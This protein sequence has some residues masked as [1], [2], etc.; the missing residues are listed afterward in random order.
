[1]MQAVAGGCR[2]SWFSKAAI[3]VWLVCAPLMYA[4]EHHGQVLS[5]NLPVP[6]ATVIAT[7]GMKKFATVTDV[8]GRYAFP[9]LPDGV[10]QL[11][12]EMPFFTTVE[13]AITV[14]PKAPAAKWNLKVLP[15]PQALAQIKM[16]KTATSSA[17]ASSTSTPKVDQATVAKKSTNDDGLL[18]NGSMDNAATSRF[19]LNQAFGNTR[20]NSHNLYNGGFG[21]VLGNSALDARPYSLTGLDTPQSNYSEVTLLADIGGPLNIPHLWHRGPNFSAL[22]LW[23]RDSTAIAESGLVPTLAQRTDTV[24][25]TDPVAQALLAYY[26]LPNL[27]GN[28]NY[29]YQIPVL[30]GTH[31]DAPQIRMN[32]DIGSSGDSIS[33]SFALESTR[34][35][36]TNLFGFRDNTATLGLNTTINYDHRFANNL[37][38]HLT[39][40]FS[41]SRN[42][43]TPFF[44]NLVNVAG[45]AGLTGVNQNP[46]NWGPPTLIFSSGIASLTDAQSQFNRNETN[47]IGGNVQ[48]NLRRHS[49]TAG[50]DFRREEFNYFAQQ[51]PRGTFT[52][53]GQAYGSDIADFLHGVPDTASIVYGNPD[54]YL[55]ESVYDVY[56]TDDWHLAPDFTVNYGGRLEY[57]APITE[58]KD[59]LANLD[60]AGSFAAVAPVTAQIPKGSLTGRL[61]PSSLI[62]PDRSLIEPRIGIA[63]RPLAGSSLLVRGGYGIYADTSVYQNIAIQLAQQAP[64]AK[65]ISANN[66]TCSQSLATGPSA[67]SA[68]TVDT[69][70]IDPNFRIGFAQTWQASAQRDLPGALQL[71][72]TYLGIKGSN[73]VQQFLPNTYP[74]GAMNPCPACP[75]G[76]SYQTS[77]GS[78]TREAGSIQLRRRLRSG[79]TAS[80]SY[81]YSKSIDDDSVLGGQ[82]PLAAGSASSASANVAIA[83]NW[84][85]LRAE[86][87]LSA[88]DQRH[89]VSAVL[90][91]TTGMGLGGGTLM[92]GWL[93]RIYKEWTVVNTVM[94][95]TGLPETPVYLAA[96]TGT[97]FSGSI[98]PDRTSASIYAAPTG[99]FLNPS[100]FTAPQPGKWGTAGRDSITGPGQLT[101]DSSLARTFRIS[102][103]YNLNARVDA[104]NLL[105][106][107]VFTSYNTTVDPTLSSPIFGLPTATAAMRSLQFTVRLRF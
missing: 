31:I 56:A 35:D 38:A 21:L 99:R 64:F 73:G 60:V 50:A 82:G 52:F 33:G 105:N 72:V 95:G 27:A 77:G 32:R 15:L 24:T 57:S 55:R 69:F 100:A 80:V 85:N 93:G 53:T 86:R 65:S 2:R 30:N 20:K 74:I 9:N 103:R 23:R 92:Q 102:S 46:A 71:L 41:H 61:Y 66:A 63:W 25:A 76:F 54:K 97:G 14:A 40:R 58:V 90:Q 42:E 19:S 88:F 104:T 45:D 59:R 1:V 29:N 34:E 84:L 68:N 7:Q 28:A 39:Y 81:T 98:R 83:Q 47:S 94:A 10:W 6:G 101:F 18:V 75:T 13:Q 89:L 37:Y 8:Q 4:S 67:C 79:L 26:P 96:V 48:W 87:S 43:V 91:Y 78:S 62:H 51:N 36:T 12:V 17:V 107:V 5:N 11:E 70:G 3:A 106:H 49:I 16:M 22:Y 44:E